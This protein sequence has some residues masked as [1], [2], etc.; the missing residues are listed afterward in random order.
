MNKRFWKGR[1][2]LVTGG[3]GFLGTGLVKELIRL[4]AKVYVLSS[5]RHPRD[6]A[7]SAALIAGDISNL[8]LIQRTL[9]KQKIETVFH[10][11]AKATVEAGNNAPLATLETNIRGTWAIL[12]AC[13]RTS[14][15][16]V[17][18]ASSSKACGDQSRPLE[19]SKACAERL[20]HVYFKTYGLPVSVARLANCYG[21]GDR[22]F[23][24]IIPETI[25][26]VLKG[27][28]PVIRGDGKYR[29][30]LLFIDDAVRGFIELAEK[31]G[32]PGVS[33]EIFNFAGDGRFSTLGIVGAILK[34]MSQGELKPLILKKDK[35]KAKEVTLSSAK[36]RKV[37]NWRPRSKIEEGLR[38]TIFWYASASGSPR[39]ARR[40]QILAG[41]RAVPLGQRGPVAPIDRKPRLP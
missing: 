8:E 26:A 27:E 19:Y 2:V 22:N 20:T 35:R 5:A 15:K 37:L 14:V 16:G 32:K 7:S 41:R 18:I 40:Q 31:I 13:R 24:R 17:V 25:L 1:R 33:G 10:L 3:T 34:I 11:A 30:Q 23:S 38:R 12:E 39:K 36:A 6:P 28:R 21:G 4:K 29:F 9:I